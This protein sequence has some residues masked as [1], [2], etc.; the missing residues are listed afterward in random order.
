MSTKIDDKTEDCSLN[1]NKESLDCLIS[2]N[3]TE[4]THYPI[5][6]LISLILLILSF[7]K[8]NL[9]FII[10]NMDSTFSLMTLN[11]NSHLNTLL[12]LTKLPLKESSVKIKKILK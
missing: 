8:E 1:I 12:S 4:E 3:L 11:L 7:K 6:N 2:S 5:Q 10:K 9:N